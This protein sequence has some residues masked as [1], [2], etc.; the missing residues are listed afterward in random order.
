MFMTIVG[1]TVIGITSTTGVGITGMARLG[2]GVGI[3][4]T[5]RVGDLAGELAGE[6]GEAGTILGMVMAI[7]I[8]I[9]A[10]IIMVAEEVALTAILQTD[11]I[12]QDLDMV[13][14][15]IQI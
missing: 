9:T 1:D 4:G 12:I 10:A 7:I 11:T 6:A 8:G 15:T 14:E 5:A 3:V 2:V 13:S